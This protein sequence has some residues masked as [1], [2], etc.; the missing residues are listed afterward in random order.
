MAALIEIL[1]I[2]QSL[3]EQD[4]VDRKNVQLLGKNE[5]PS[6]TPRHVHINNSFNQNQHSPILLDQKCL[7]CSQQVPLVLQAF[8]MACLAY[9]PGQVKF[10]SKKYS[11]NYMLGARGKLIQAI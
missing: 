6:I 8:K 3:D 2:T 5:L 4:D 7:S 1:Q 10:G 11:R 9:L